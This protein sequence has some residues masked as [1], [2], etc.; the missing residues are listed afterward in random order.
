MV[1]HIS[2]IPILLIFG[3]TC[4][5][6][7][8]GLLNNLTWKKSDIEVVIQFPC[9]LGT[10]CRNQCSLNQKRRK[11]GLSENCETKLNISQIGIFFI[12]IFL[13]NM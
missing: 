2:E 4:D 3:F 12:I 9:V 13:V 1:D 11:V 8:V 7:K 10:P 6:E 5:T